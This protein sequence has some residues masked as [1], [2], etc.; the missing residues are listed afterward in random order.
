MSGH[1]GH[2]KRPVRPHNPGRQLAPMGSGRSSTAVQDRVPVTDELSPPVA[3]DSIA[4]NSVALHSLLERE[5]WTTAAA[6]ATPRGKYPPAWSLAIVMD[7][8]AVGIP[9]LWNPSYV[10]AFVALC[11]L[12]ITLLAAGGMYRP[13]LHVST[14]DDIPR[15][16][17]RLLIAIAAV[18]TVIALRHDQPA[19]GGFLRASVFVVA[20]MVIGRFITTSS[21]RMVRRRMWGSRTAVLVGAGPV[22]LELA[23]LLERHPGYGQHVIGFVDADQLGAS[24]ESS[25]P[26][27]GRI[28]DLAMVIDHHKVDTLIVADPAVTDAL[29]A[30]I[31]RS[32]INRVG[33]ILVVPRLH[34]FQ[35]QTGMPDHIGAIPIMRISPPVLSGWQRTL[36]RSIDVLVSALA[37]IVLAPLF[38]LCAVLV[39]ID[40]GSGVLFRQQRVGRDG[41]LFEILKFRSMRPVDNHESQT[42]WSIAADNRVSVIGRLLRRTSLDEI[43]QLWNIFRGEMTL[44]GPRPERPFFVERFTSEYQD[45]GW[46]HRVPAGLTGLAQVSGLRGDT[47]ICDRARFDNYYIENWS[48]WLDFKIVVRTLREVVSAAGR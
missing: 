43:P 19:V 18:A 15:L 5:T 28:D 44:V 7:V 30:E 26:L 1:N 20:S 48:L 36:K 34:Q 40:G 3:A 27:L 16:L 47:P 10:R 24:P 12:S 22:G 9:V 41:R 32:A 39:R 37:M 14:L 13:R 25:I 21:I 42:N 33:D 46:R 2:A 6:K 23:R 4:A 35:T 31:V 17:G 38:G 45:Y 11:L 8:V 29:L